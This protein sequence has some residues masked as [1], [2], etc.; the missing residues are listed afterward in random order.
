MSEKH[1]KHH[2]HE[3]SL[4]SSSRPFIPEQIMLVDEFTGDE[5]GSIDRE[6]AHRE[7]IWHA[8]IHVWIVD[9]KGRL[10]FQQRAKWINIYPDL[11]DISAAGHIKAGEKDSFREVSEE[12]GVKPEKD[13]IVFLGTLTARQDGTGFTNRERP[14]VYL[15][16]S[17]LHL[18]DFSFPDDEVQSL[19]AIERVDI[20]A[21]LSGA[22]VIAEVLRDGK[23]SYESISG[24]KVVPHSP[25]YWSVIRDALEW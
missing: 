1:S 17:L 19:A 21:F 13:E 25:A 12:L 9:A 14:Q 18:K 24:Q 15:W 2:K 10:L 4:E 7:G 5:I 11:W 16:P 20:E 3:E 6:T 22:T 23:I 8:S